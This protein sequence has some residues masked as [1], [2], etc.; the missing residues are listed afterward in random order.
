MRWADKT[1]FRNTSK[2]MFIVAI[3]LVNSM[4]MRDFAHF[5]AHA[6]HPPRELPT[7]QSCTTHDA[8]FH[9]VTEAE[10]PFEPPCWNLRLVAVI[11]PLCENIAHGGLR[12]LPETRAP[13]ASV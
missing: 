3:L 4:A 9:C 11:Q 7:P 12:L 1:I 6:N 10:A 8:I 13:P 5:K 2:T